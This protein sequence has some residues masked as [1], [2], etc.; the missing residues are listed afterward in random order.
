MALWS[1]TSTSTRTLMLGFALF[2]FLVNRIAVGGGG[3]LLFYI[4]LSFFL[5]LSF[6]RYF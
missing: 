6:F 4:S 2:V 3:G 5:F 1:R